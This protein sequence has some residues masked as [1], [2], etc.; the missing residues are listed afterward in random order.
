VSRTTSKP[1]SVRARIES[2]GHAFRGIGVMLGAE[3]NAWIHAFA[4][5]LAIGLGFFLDIARGEWLAVMLAIALV[6]VA[7]ALNTAVEALGDALTADPNPKVKEAKDA[8]AGGVLISALAALVIGLFVFG[9]KL[10][11][12]LS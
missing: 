3:H 6:W 1:F 2:F 7:E 9:R 5:L 8:A 12:Y 4:T 11:L 10:L